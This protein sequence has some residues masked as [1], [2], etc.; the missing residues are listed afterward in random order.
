MDKYFVNF[1]KYPFHITRNVRY[2]NNKYSDK[3]GECMKLNKFTT[4]DVIEKG[5]PTLIMRYYDYETKFKG[6]I[7]FIHGVSHGAWCWEYFADYFSKIGYSCFAINLRGHGDDNKNK[8]G[9]L[10]KYVDDVS[11]C[12]DYCKIYCKNNNKPYSKPSVLGHSM[13]GAIVEIYMNE[14][15]NQI[16]NAILFAPATAQGIKLSAITST[17]SK[18]GL[19]TTPTI[20]GAKTN[21]H[22]AE[23]NFFVAKTDNRNFVP[24]ITDKKELELYDEQLCSENIIAL[25]GLIC[26]TLN[27]P[28]IPI[29]VIGSDKDAYFPTKSLHK[30]ASFYDTKEMVLRGLCHD[31]MLD[32]ERDKAAQSILEFI[33]HPEDLKNNPEKFINNLE[34]KL[35]SIDNK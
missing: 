15:T 10:K 6:I 34:Q 28:N 7:V 11:R 19:Y 13:G 5:K 33:K 21:K 23:S 26:Y 31:M 1:N 8:K 22:L 3:E 25:L 24:R 14:H 12:I 30:T 18:T 16:K 29:F 4:V 20:T 27:K 32:P 35:Y 9:T 2:I 17:I